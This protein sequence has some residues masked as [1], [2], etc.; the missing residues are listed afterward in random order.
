MQKQQRDDTLGESTWDDANPETTLKTT[1][2]CYKFDF[3]M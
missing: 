1:K 2:L 3:I